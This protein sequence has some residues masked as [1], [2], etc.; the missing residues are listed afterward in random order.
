MGQRDSMEDVEAM[1]NAAE[2][3]SLGDQVNRQIRTNQDWSLLP[4]QGI[5]GAIAPC[6]LTKG[7]SLYP[8]FP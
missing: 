3:I 8:A 2:F 1:A 5:C 4:Q 6:L 7:R